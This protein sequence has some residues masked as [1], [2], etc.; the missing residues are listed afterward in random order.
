[1]TGIADDSRKDLRHA[2]YWLL[3][4][5]SAGMMIGRVLTVRSSLGKTPLLCANDRSRWC[6]IRA[7]VD[8]GTYVIDDVMYKDAARTKRDREWYT[9][10]RVHHK[11]YDGSE[12]DYSSKPPLLPTLLAGPYWVL[13]Q[14][15]GV[16]I[17][18]RP[19]YV[20]RCML[21]LVNVLPLILY[22]LLLARMAE[23]Y[24]TTDWG[25]LF[26][27][28]AA[29]Y[30]TFL[31]T[32]AVTLNNHTVAAVSVAITIHAAL[33]IWRDGERRLRYFAI[34]GF[35]AAFTAANELPAL[36]FLAVVAFAL[37][38][39]SPGRT[40]AAF[41]PAVLLVAAGFFGTNFL[42]HGSWRPPYAHRGNGPVVAVCIGNYTAE[43]GRGEVPAALRQVLSDIDIE[44]SEQTTVKPRRSGEGWVLWDPKGH[45]R[46]ALEADR[47]S[48]RAMAWDHWYEH[49]D[50][51]WFGDQKSDVDLGESSR[52]VYA[53]HVLVGHH[54]VLSLTPLW[55][56]SALG[57]GLW[58]ARDEPRMRG[59][60]LMVLGLSLVCLAFYIARPLKDRNYG[61]ICSGFRWMFWFIPLWLVALLPAAD[62]IARRRWAQYLALLL[63]LASVVSAGYA[64]LNPWTHPWIYQYSVYL[65]EALP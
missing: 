58:L 10:D 61:G 2:I 32:F 39:R 14:L 50:S 6:T 60:A 59:F 35:F 27:M 48:L 49:D 19:F 28:A 12:H 30:G 13:K 7:L 17:A 3:I 65:S 42:A 44:L 43:V 55:L 22:F 9:I 16:T 18:E 38:L 26:C 36:S 15:T 25:R 8:H 52:A 54:G 33:P 51:Y 63:L 23:R 20:V 1:M 47:A 21:I 11:G 41:T 56:L 24:G 34:A 64:C 57:I 4:V 62:W 46:L 29:V 5:T 45:D 53:F 37:F 31:T 40:L